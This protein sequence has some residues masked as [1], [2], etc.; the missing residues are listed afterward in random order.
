MLR[1][2][3]GL[4]AFGFVNFFSRNFDNLLIGRVWGSNQL[5]LYSRAYQLL[6][7]PI[8][9][10]NSPIAAVA[11]PAL[12]RIVDAEE[13]YRQMYLRILAN[14]A[15]VT[16]AGT[17]FMIVTADWLIRIVLGPQWT[18]AG[19]I[20]VPLGI[21]GLLQPVANATGWLFITQGRTNQMFQWG[22]VAGTLT[23]A[24]F[25]VGL[26]W[27]AV[28]VAVSYAITGVCSAPLLFWWVGRS[29]PVKTLDIYHAF[30]PALFSSL[31]GLLMVAV[32]RARVETISPLAGLSIAFFIFSVTVLTVLAVTPSTRRA[33]REFKPL[34][35]LLAGRRGEV[36]ARSGRGDASADSA[37]RCGSV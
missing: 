22:L 5:G 25:L 29:G 9:Q 16:M 1:F 26:P 20:F 8:D 27:G 18:E 17:A 6:L 32:F 28:G 2:G 33:L 37:R 23:T 12:S 15:I 24:S 34:L 31:C 36:E 19:R 14:L 13:R 11:V 7:L 4:T 35:L 30:V 3:L 10:I 21:I